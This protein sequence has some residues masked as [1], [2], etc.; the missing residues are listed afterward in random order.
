V[1]D[2]QVPHAQRIFDLAALFVFC[3]IIA[4]GLSDTPGANWIARRAERSAEQPIHV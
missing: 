3:S 1:L 4:H 2:Q